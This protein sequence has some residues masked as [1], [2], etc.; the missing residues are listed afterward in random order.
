VFCHFDGA[1]LRAV[2]ATARSG[3]LGRE[4]VFPSGRRCRTFEDLARGCA[5]EWN[6]AR[7]M[8]Q[9]GSLRQFMAG[10]GRMDLALAAD[11]AAATADQDLGLDQFISQLPMRDGLGPKLDIEPRRFKIGP[12]RVGESRQVKLQIWNQGTGLLHGSLQIEGDDWIRFAQDIGNTVPI[13]TGKQQVV[14]FN[15][16]TFG[17]PAGGKFAAKLTVLT[18]GGVVEV[19]VVLEVQAAA[20][21]HPPLDGATSP[22]ELAEKIKENPKQAVPFLEGGEVQKWFGA[23]GWRY[24]VQGPPARGM[25]GIQQLFEGMGVSK[26]P[27]VTVSDSGVLMICRLGQTVR[28]HVTL[29]S[30]VKKW[31]YGRVESDS[32]WLSVSNPDVGGAQQA[33]IDFEANS[34]GLAGGKSYAG[35]LT[36][37]ANGGQRFPVTV[38]LEVRAARIS[39]SRAFVRCLLVGGL[40]AFLLRLLLSLPDVFARG[41]MQ[42]GAWLNP[43]SPDHPATFVRDF[44]LATAWLGIPLGGILLWRRSSLPN[45]LVLL[46][47][48]AGVIVGGVTG[49]LAGATLGCL[50]EIL[51]KHAAP[52]LPLRLPGS[53]IVGWTM[54]GLALG[55]A[56]SV[57]GRVGRS[58]IDKVGR[59]LGWLCRRCGLEGPGN[60]LAGD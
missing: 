27:V 25:A 40:A 8:L 59:P 16:D 26:P 15:I 12:L 21:P 1:E 11:R 31:V 17:L 57:L 50:L 44:T 53:A 14:L 29:R 56:C 5:E 46:D 20:F 13:K 24:P 36:V 54:A 22:R 7:N 33:S 38:R 43:G 39:L 37:T 34:T 35:K 9:Q 28:G 48:L 18:N 19:P 6:S 32:S 49:L 4:F 58:I 51:E 2:G 10:I 23:N 52:L 41:P 30:N 55:L 3:D 47:V 60:L 45:V 42:F